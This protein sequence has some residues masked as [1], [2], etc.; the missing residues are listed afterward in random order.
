LFNI[1]ESGN[2]KVQF[3]VNLGTKTLSTQTATAG[4]DGNSDASQVDGFSPV[5]VMDVFGTGVAKHNP[6][7][8]AGYGCYITKPT[9]STAGGLCGS[10]YAN[11]V[12]TPATSLGSTYQWYK[13]NVA[14]VGA[15]AQSYLTSQNGLYKIVISDTSGCQAED[16]VSI[17]VSPSA[18]VGFFINDTNQCLSSQGFQFVNTSGGAGYA[19]SIW[20]TTQVVGTPVTLD[21]LAIEVGVKFRTSSIGVVKGLRFY[22]L[23]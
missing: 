18:N 11:L 12:S 19:G 20:D 1:Y 21:T 3:P 13:N 10:G 15:T 23:A 16:T 2:Y 8:D 14:I 4:T 22:K 17:A 6:T 9:I 5:I 7:I